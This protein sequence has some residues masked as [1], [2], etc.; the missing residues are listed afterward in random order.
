[1]NQSSD[2]T[3][4]ELDTLRVDPEK[5]WQK[6]DRRKLT[7]YDRT[8]FFCPVIGKKWFQ[9][10]TAANQWKSMNQRQKR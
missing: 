5:Q 10:V 8:L 1:M 4:F 9:N 3:K 7:L 6:S 2:R